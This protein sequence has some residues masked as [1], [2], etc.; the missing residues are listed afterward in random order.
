MFNNMK[1]FI[2]PVLLICNTAYGLSAS[3]GGSSRPIAII[4]GGT[5]GIGSGISEALADAG[6]DLLL[7]YNTN[8]DAAKEFAKSL[9]EREESQGCQVECVGGDIS[10]PDTR[11]KIFEVLDSVYAGRPLKAM[12]HN[13]GQYVGVT[14]D[15][16]DNLKSSP[17]SFGDGSLSNEDG[18]TNFDTMHYYQRMY[19][20][21][22]V[23]LCERSVTRMSET[24]GGSLI[25]ISSPGV[26][27][28]YYGP[29]SSYS[30]PGAGKCLMEYSMRIYAT[31]AA[32]R[33]INAN[34]IVPGVVR[35]GAWQK[36]A[37]SR[38]L[39]DSTEMIQG[40]ADRICPQKKV[41]SPRDIGNSVAF[42]C[43]DAGRW[44]TGTVMPVDGG[45]HL[46][47]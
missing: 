20:E 31:K 23:D 12:V 34:V 14:S 37:E 35:S 9:L 10:L 39:T 41:M 8:K 32:E 40:I 33:N 46:T 29:D 11:R 6:Y 36:L 18:S 22:F 1:S 13:A 19:G 27:A 5:R 25:G 26:T 24:G 17:L 2:C 4:S 28:H 15:N 3:T 45:I 30:M 38:G 21:A 42:L 7:T 16:S 47:R 43:S 44:I